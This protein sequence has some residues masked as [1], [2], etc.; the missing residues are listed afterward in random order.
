[1]GA[2]ALLSVGFEDRF[3]ALH[4]VPCSQ[5][6]DIS[7]CCYHQ[8][9]SIPVAAVILLVAF[10]S[11][12]PPTPPPR[13]CLKHDQFEATMSDLSTLNSD[14]LKIANVQADYNLQKEAYVYSEVNLATGQSTQTMRT[15]VDHKIS[16]A[17]NI[18]AD[19]PTKCVKTPYNVPMNKCLQDD[20]VYIG[21]NY[22]GP[23]A[24]GLPYD[25]YRLKVG[26]IDVLIAL[27]KADCVPVLQG[28]HGP[29][30]NTTYLYTTTKFTLSDPSQFDLP[31]SCTK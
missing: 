18:P 23:L 8:N 12:Q 5:R 25:A 28:V 7:G 10:A 13:C 24:G 6:I 26:A 4:T 3:R 2:G 16:I 29:G 27:S 22:L 17:Y 19:D 30:I 31:P 21:S 11:A 1:M 14:K 9:M 20:A 15:V